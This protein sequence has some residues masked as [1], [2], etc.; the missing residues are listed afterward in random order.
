MII[1]TRPN[2]A[3]S[4][5]ILIRTAS[6]RPR[7]RRNGCMVLDPVRVRSSKAFDSDPVFRYEPETLPEV[8]ACPRAGTLCQSKRHRAGSPLLRWSLSRKEPQALP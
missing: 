5:P 7:L 6:D 4:N 2:P 8:Y 3:R 1:A